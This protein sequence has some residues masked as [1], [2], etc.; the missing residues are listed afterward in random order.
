MNCY[1]HIFK[2]FKFY[3]NIKGFSFK[4]KLIILTQVL[5]SE[6]LANVRINLQVKK[7]F[8]KINFKFLI[9]TFEG[10]NFEKII[11]NLAKS[12]DSKIQNIGYQYTSILK[13]QDSLFDFQKTDYY[14]DIIFTSG[15][16]YKKIFEK[17]T[18]NKSIFI[19]GSNKL[20]QKILIN[21]NKENF[22]L[23]IPEAIL[24]ECKLLFQFTIEYTKRYDN[25]NFIWRLHP[26]MKIDN[27]L[28]QLR[29]NKKDL[30]NIYFSDNSDEDFIK[31]KY[32]LYRG[33]TA[34][35]QGLKNLC[36]P[37]YLNSNLGININPI[38]DIKEIENINSIDGLNLVVNKHKKD[39]NEIEIDYKISQYFNVP[40]QK[41]IDLL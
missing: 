10:F 30:N 29:I 33:S 20:N 14:P 2:L 39:L 34:I 16:Y 9:S 17:Y 22:C 40:S 28:N 13:D 19:A 24:S 18:F 27:V 37:V 21:K 12:K 11:Y 8:K 36:Y 23:V 3:L 35:I 5:N 26:L 25:L 31:S 41:L 1:A 15:D 4:E 6:T 32:C 7:I 38:Y